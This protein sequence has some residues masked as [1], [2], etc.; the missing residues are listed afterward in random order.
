MIIMY[1]D[2]SGSPSYADHTNYYVLSGVIIQDDYIK[3]LQ[4]AVFNYKQNNFIG[5]FIDEKIH[6]HD[7]YKAKG[8]FETINLT[9]K[10]SL[11]K[12]L[13]NMVK[14]L[15]CTAISVV[16]NKDNFKKEHSTWKVSNIALTYLIER[17]DKYLE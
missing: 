12:N 9:T 11:L 6:T 16:I 10:T 5:N 7:I 2:D 14:E 17:Y 13:Y 8:N 3:D 1:V 15:E 4:K